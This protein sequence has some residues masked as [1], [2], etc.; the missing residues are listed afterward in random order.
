MVMAS[1][2]PPTFDTSE[3]I[4]FRDILFGNLSSTSTQPQNSVTVNSASIENAVHLSF[5]ESPEFST[6]FTHYDFN[7]FDLC[8]EPSEFSMFYTTQACV[9]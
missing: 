4:L 3:D 6:L 5:E 7:L 8:E 2:N 1:N 9:L